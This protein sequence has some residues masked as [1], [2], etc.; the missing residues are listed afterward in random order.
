MVNVY[1]LTDSTGCNVFV[2]RQAM[3]REGYWE[4]DLAIRGLLA[5]EH[6]HPLVEKETVRASRRLNMALSLQGLNLESVDEGW[7]QRTQSLLTLLADKLCLYAPREILANDMAIRSGFGEALL[8]LDRL[9]VAQA[10]QSVAGREGLCQHLQREVMQKT[11]TPE[12]ADLL[13]LIGDLKGYLDL[14]LEIAPFYRTGWEKEARE[15]E[16]ALEWDI[17]PYL[18]PQAGR[19]YTTLRDQYIGLDTDLSPPELRAWSE[20]TLSTLAGALAEKGLSLEYRVW[21]KDG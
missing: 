6:A 11:L 16:T 17:F 20:G 19:A 12:A 5:H 10:S 2:N 3:V 8:H 18:E 1:D 4:D 21:M 13:L 14:A 9:I 15:L 7:G